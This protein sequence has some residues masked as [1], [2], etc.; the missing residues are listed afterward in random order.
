MFFFLFSASPSTSRA[1]CPTNISPTTISWTPVGPVQFTITGTNCKVFVTYCTR[2]YGGVIEYYIDVIT[3]DPNNWGS[4]CGSLKWIDVINDIRTQLMKTPNAG[5]CD[6]SVSTSVAVYTGQCVSFIVQNGIP[7]AN[8]CADVY[9]KKQCELCIQ[10]G[11]KQLR[12]CQ[13]SVIGSA[14]CQTLTGIED[15]TFDDVAFGP[16][17]GNYGQC[18]FIGCNNLE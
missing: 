16:F 11:V 15:L 9:C 17:G 2:T 8:F 7:A 12:N 6:W 5:D 13:T 10:G 1:G 18:Y 4:G 3:P 14:D